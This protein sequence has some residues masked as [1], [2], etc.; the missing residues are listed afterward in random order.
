MLLSAMNI[1]GNRNLD[2][3]IM[4]MSF[5]YFP[6]LAHRPLSVKTRVRADATFFKRDC[7]LKFFLNLNF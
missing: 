4:P 5:I 7:F 2:R 3:T 6:R 1:V